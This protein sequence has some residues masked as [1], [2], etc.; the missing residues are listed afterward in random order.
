MTDSPG[1]ASER[2]VL[3]ALVAGGFLVVVGVL[4]LGAAFAGLVPAWW[5]VLG[6]VG[7]V[8]VGVL[9][10]ARWRDT[11]LVLMSSILLFF[12]WVVGTLLV[13]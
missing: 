8:A 12:S 10:A 2:Q 7:V 9:A 4:V 3:Y 5:T 6:S 11:R 13:A 1:P